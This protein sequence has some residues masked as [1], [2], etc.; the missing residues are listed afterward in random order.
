[1]GFAICKR[2]VHYCLRPRPALFQPSE[3]QSAAVLKAQLE[4]DQ[5][6]QQRKRLEQQRYEA[7]QPFSYEPH[8]YPWCKAATPFDVR[9]QPIVDEARRNGATDDTR[10]AARAL[11]TENAALVRRAQDGDEAALDELAQ[12][13]SVVLNPVTGEI[14]PIYTLC[15]QLNPAGDCP[16]YETTVA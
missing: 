13:R 6:D 4:W 8:A 3:L 15:D 2:C 12:H 14:K 9:L 10:A 1:M 16:L 11:A 7:G 5:E